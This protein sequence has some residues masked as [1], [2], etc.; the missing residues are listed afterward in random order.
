MAVGVNHVSN[1]SI[2]AAERGGGSH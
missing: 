2:L 1:K